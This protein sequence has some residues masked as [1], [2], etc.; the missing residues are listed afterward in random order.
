MRSD[1][2]IRRTYTRME[3][4]EEWRGPRTVRGLSR[5][6]PSARA[7]DAG[8]GAVAGPHGHVMVSLWSS[9]LAQRA[10]YESILIMLQ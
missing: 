10:L 5:S 6:T 2:T 9:G 7:G 3:A 1:S 8:R 4:A